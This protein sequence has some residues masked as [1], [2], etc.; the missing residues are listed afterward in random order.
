MV[1]KIN[2]AAVAL[3]GILLLVC[4]CRK[5]EEVFF[6][7][8]FVRLED[9]NGASSLS[10]DRNLD[11]LLTE[12]RIVVSASKN[13]FTEPIVVEYE[14]IPGDGLKEGSDFKVQASTMS[15]QTFS[16]GTYSLPVRV[17]WYKTDNFDPDKDNTLTF[18][19]TRTSLPEMLLGCPGK[20]AI[21]KEFIFTK[22]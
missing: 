1:T 13:Y 9:V 2:K 12:I 14:I 11:N 7:T 15:P 10:V 6:D 22:L 8:P 16:P 5:H 21:K 19:L 20:D 18:R 3:A 17:I 4:G